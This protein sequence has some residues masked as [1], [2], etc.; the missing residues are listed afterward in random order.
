MGVSRKKKGR[1]PEDPDLVSM[2]SSIFVTLVAIF[3]CYAVVRVGGPIAM[4]LLDRTPVAIVTPSIVP[5]ATETSAPHSTFTPT[6][7]PTSTDS[8][9]QTPLPTPLEEIFP[10]VDDGVQFIFPDNEP[11]LFKKQFIES[12]DC[13][14]SGPFGLQLTYN[15]TAGGGGG[16]GVHW[17]VP[18]L[19]HFD[20]PQAG[21]TTLT[22]W[23]KG[24][25]G[26]ETFQ[27]GL[28]DTGQI[29]VKVDSTRYV[30]V[31]ASEWRPVE[32]PLSHFADSNGSVNI[33]SIENMN[34]SFE[35]ENGSG[36][37]CIDDIAF[38]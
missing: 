6:D 31:S 15:F 8:P 1:P 27:I 35:Q 33:A 9:S 20:A 34:F 19:N 16:W 21:F 38:R 36:I 32:I 18:P 37:I 17:S 25:L 26:G 12:G 4:N 14:H 29:E 5:S 24:M 13:R 7:A 30:Q 11:N 23:V 22:F 3:I 28:K 10:Q 2:G